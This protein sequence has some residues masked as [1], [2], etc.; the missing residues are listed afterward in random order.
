MVNIEDRVKRLKKKKHSTNKLLTKN[1]PLSII[2]KV[3]FVII[4]FLCFSIYFKIYPEHKEAFRNRA[5]NS[6][7]FATTH[8]FVNR[9][10]DL[11]PLRNLATNNYTLPVFGENLHF[12]DKI[13]YNDGVKLTVDE[14]YLVPALQSGIVVFLGNRDGHENIVVVQQVNGIDVWYIGMTNINT[15]IYDF[16]E[17]GSFLGNTI[18]DTLHLIFKRDGRI[19][20]YEE[21]I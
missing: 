21:H 12:S 16:V 19:V 20:D 15:R 17:R 2:N 4:I 9:F 11:I 1:T 5:R 7:N 10:V 6:F 8:S 13:S 3:F 18:D 14:N